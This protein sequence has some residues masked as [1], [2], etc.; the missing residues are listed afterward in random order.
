MGVNIG[1]KVRKGFEPYGFYRKDDKIINYAFST[2]TTQPLLERYHMT[3]RAM[4]NAISGLQSDSSW[5]DVIGNNIANVNTLAYKYSRAEFA[6]QFSQSLSSGNGANPLTGQGGTDPVEIGTGTRL[7]TIQTIFNQGVIQNTGNSLDVAI[8]GQ[9]FLAVKN[10]DQ[11]Y[12]T[13]AGN[14]TIDGQGYLVDSNGDHVQ[15]F[16]AVN[17]I[18]QEQINAQTPAVFE[19]GIEIAAPAPSLWVTSDSLK[20]NNTDPTQIQDIRLDTQMTLLPKATTEVTF[21]GNL[22]SW[23][24]ANQ[25]GGV[26]DLYPIQG[27]T[28]PVAFSMAL[29]NFFDPPLNN[30]IDTRRMQTTVNP[31]PGSDYSLQQVNG[32]STQEPG[33]TQIEPLLNGFIPLSAAIAGQGNYAWEQSP[34]LPPACQSNETVY[35]STGNAHTISVLFY[36]VNDLGTANPPINPSPLNQACYVWYAFDT[37]GGQPIK[38]A[39]M[40]GGTGIEEGD[41][42]GQGSYN[43][44]SQDTLYGG[45]FLWFN[46]DGSLAST[47]GVGG[48]FPTPAGLATNF[49]SIPRV[50]LPLSNLYPPVSPIPTL[51]AEVMPVSLNF[52]TAGFLGVGRRDGLFSDA[53]GS[54]QVIN[55]VNTYVPNS[56]VQA[57]SQDG[58]PDG[59]L[60]SLSFQPDGT[61]TGSFTNNQQI[62]LAQVALT[63]PGNPGGLAQV[64]TNYFATSANSGP[65]NTGVAGQNGLGTVRGGSLELSNV[66]LSLEL[67]NM[68]LAQRGFDTNARMMSA[69]DQTLQ[70]LDNLGQGG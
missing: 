10:G 28:L 60:Q 68:I 33:Y 49:E 62:A 34:P 3:L 55:G 45:D 69:V 70:V 39:N 27:P 31:L 22:D 18:T 57:V 23:Q 4:Y 52:G 20:L 19:G 63:Q 46:T 25:P 61:L 24:Q 44:T 66:D 26:L 15:G 16:N 38:T 47:G 53:E 8:D 32:L 43:R 9:G 58:Y 59:T 13:R 37:T 30:A 54:F 5:M 64:G 50:Y 29:I 11:T 17:S 14:L 6:T 67:S 42:A 12:Y 65:L 48:I 40:L 51:G 56:D 41:F 21:Q 1:K 35:D 2:P 36:Q 7:E